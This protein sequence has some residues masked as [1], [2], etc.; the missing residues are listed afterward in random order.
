MW[1]FKEPGVFPA[2]LYPSEIGLPTTPI[3]STNNTLFKILY[4]HWN[5]KQTIVSVLSQATS[6]S[7]DVLV[8]WQAMLFA[9]DTNTLF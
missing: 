3:M 5:G 2:L 8:S 7:I 4:I 1:N 9:C 6:L